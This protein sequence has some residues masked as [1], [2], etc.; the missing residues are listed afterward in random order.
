MTEWGP[1]PGIDET[2]AEAALM[3]WFG[4][5]GYET[6]VGGDIAPATPRAERAGYRDVVLEGRLRAAIARLNP[7]A[8][9]SA[10]DEALRKVLRTQSPSLLVNNR[11]FHRMLVNPPEIEV[12]RERGGIRGVP[13][14]LVDFEEPA[15]NDW[16]AV[17]QVTV[18]GRSYRRPDVVIFVNGLP[19]G[20]IE[21]K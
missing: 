5:L 8:P 13:V 21:L 18:Q 1:L 14:R 17:N 19:L 4:E 10:G 16:L 11:S 12:T 7:D 6:R 20:L 3:E 2:V 15:N 9:S